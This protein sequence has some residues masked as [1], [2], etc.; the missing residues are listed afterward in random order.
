MEI[1]DDFLVMVCFLAMESLVGDYAK[2]KKLFV[3]GK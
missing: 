2:V 3:R 1:L